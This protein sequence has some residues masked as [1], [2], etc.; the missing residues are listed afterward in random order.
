MNL[1]IAYVTSRL[2]PRF[3]W[4]F[5]SLHRETGGDYSG[6]NIVVV[7]RHA[8]RELPEHCPILRHVPPKASVWQGPHR[9]T[10]RDYFAASNTRNTAICCAPDGWIA[11]VDDLSVLMPGWLE[12]V[13]TAMRG[14]YIAAGA[15]KKVNDLIVEN[16]IA[17]SYDEHAKGID[18]R[19]HYGDKPITIPGSQFFG[20]SF[21]AP[22]EWLLEVNGF[23]EDCDSVGGE[24]YAL[25]M[26]LQAHGRP[27]KYCRQMFTLESDEAHGEETPMIRIDKGLS[28]H[29][30]SHAMLHMIQ[31]G[32][33]TAPNYFG[34]GGIR[35]VR[36]RV[37]A[38]EPFPVTRVPDRDWYDGQLLSEM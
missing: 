10:Q 20:C 6:I 22:I 25:G 16:G 1:T 24:D 9:L 4:F 21:A 2:N 35:A 33:R 12:A 11:F 36:Q 32:R 13:R 23:D 15:Y 19:W 38:G 14:N 18:S 8:T 7:D 28:P 17:V 30:K 26:M 27:I 37:L 29:D 34:E 5:D 31:G 3:N